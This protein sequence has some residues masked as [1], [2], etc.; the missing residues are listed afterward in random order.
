VTYQQPLSVTLDELPSEDSVNLDW[1]NA[2]GAQCDPIGLAR[3]NRLLRDGARTRVASIRADKD[4]N[5]CTMI[6]LGPRESMRNAL[7][8]LI[9]QLMPPEDIW[10][11]N[12]ILGRWPRGKIMATVPLSSMEAVS[13]IGIIAP[14]MPTRIA[15]SQGPLP[16]DP[17]TAKHFKAL[18]AAI[19][20]PGLLGC[21]LT[22]DDGKV[23][24]LAG[25]WKIAE[26][27]LPEVFEHWGLT[28]TLE[29]ALAIVEGLTVGQA[30]APPLTLEAIYTPNPSDK[31]TLE[32]GPSSLRAS[33]Q[34]I[35]HIEGIEV[36]RQIAA[37]AKMLRQKTVYRTVVSLGPDGVD[38]ISVLLSDGV[39]PKGKW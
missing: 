37:A 34:F 9:T 19:Q 33:L 6:V 4:G 8:E 36:A 26:K 5:A 17:A 31:L 29:V 13:K 10:L 16:F 15:I 1:V 12:W 3:L 14:L 28:N 39:P 30:P 7:Q 32:I 25:R 35:N 24:E 20:E 18:H 23:T 22:L 11:V 38:S 21:R 27:R 2:C